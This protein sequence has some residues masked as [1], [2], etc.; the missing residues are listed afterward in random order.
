MLISL[1]DILVLFEQI[2]KELNIAHVSVVLFC[3]LDIDSLCTLKIL[4]VCLA[5]CRNFSEVKMYS[6]RYTLLLSTRSW[7]RA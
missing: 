6:I 5:S 3:G 1:R 2:Q 4:A 7:S